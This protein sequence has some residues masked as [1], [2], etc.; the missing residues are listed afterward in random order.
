MR[1]GASTITP[2]RSTSTCPTTGRRT[3]SCSS[4]PARLARAEHA[5]RS[6][7]RRSSRRCAS[8]RGC[9]PRAATS[10]PARLLAAYE[11]G[12]FPWYSAQQP[13]LW[14]SPDPRMVLVSRG[15]QGLAAAS[16]RRCA[17]A[18][19]RP[20]ST[21]AFDA[22]IRACAAPRRSGADTW[23]NDDM[24]DAYGELHRAGIR[25]LRRDLPRGDRWSGGCTASNWAA[26]SSANP[27][28]AGSATPPRWRWPGWSRSAAAA[29]IRLID[30]QVASSH[31]A[32]LGAREIPRSEFVALLRSYARRDSERPLGGRT[33]LKLHY[34]GAL[35]TMRPA[36]CTP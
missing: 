11:R 10:S 31:L 20:A 28:S 6:G 7:S 23:L 9:W 34:Q 26:C 27:C 13:I 36:S 12:M 22:V 5:T 15:I 17:T 30:C 35:C 16:P 29:R 18:P 1:R 3:R 14:W 8:P 24:I 2:P 33:R 25:P 4:E 32:S 19:T 21:R